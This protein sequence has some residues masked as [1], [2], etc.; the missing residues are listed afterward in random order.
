M[1]YQAQDYQPYLQSGCFY[2]ASKAKDQ[3][4]ICQPPKDWQNFYQGDWHC[5]LSPRPLA[6]QGWKIHL[7]VALGQE[8]EMLDVVSRYCFAHQ[9]SFKW[10]RS[11]RAWLL[12]NSK[13]ADRVASGKFITIYPEDGEFIQT[14][15][16]LAAL[17]KEFAPGPY[18]L[19][20]RRWQASP[21]YYRYGAFKEMIKEIAGQ[22]R[23]CLQ[24]PDGSWLEDRRCPYYCQPDFVQEPAELAKNNFQVKGADISRLTAY[25]IKGALHFSNGGG[26]YLAQK[27]GKNYVIKE[28][29]PAAGLDGHGQDA[30]S[31]IQKEAAWLKKLAN[32]P[33]VVDI[34]EDFQAWIH[35]YLVEDYVSEQTLGDYV[36]ENYPFYSEKRAA[37]VAQSLRIAEKLRRAVAHVHAQGVAIG[38]LQADNVMITEDGE[39]KLIDFEAAASLTAPY[40]PG[41]M[42]AGF[43]DWA[44]ETYEQADLYGLYQTIRFLFLPISNRARSSWPMQNLNLRCYF[45][46][47]AAD[48]LEDLR[49]QLL[50]KC[51]LLGK[52]NKDD[53]RQE[54]TWPSLNELR[55]NISRGIKADWQSPNLIKGDLPL[56]ED[57][58]QRLT[59]DNGAL[60]YGLLVAR[61]GQA[62]EKKKFLAWL[63]KQPMEELT[64]A[65][66]FT[67][68]AGLGGIVYELG[69]KAWGRQLI[70]SAQGT[71]ADLSLRSGLAG[72][73]LAKIALAKEEGLAKTVEL[74]KIGEEI[75]AGYEKM[76]GK[77]L[78]TGRLG[79]ILALWKIGCLLKREDFKETAKTGLDALLEKDLVQVDQHVFLAEDGRRMPYLA[80][81]TAGLALVLAAI[82]KDEPKEDRYQEI[83]K[84]AAE[85]MDSF[86]S[87]MGG[88]FT[89]YAGLMLPDLALGRKK[90]LGEKIRLLNNYLL[91][92]EEGTLVAASRGYRCSMDLAA[93]ASG[94]LLLLEGI[95]RNDASLWLPLVQTKNWQLF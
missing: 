65:G 71:S 35:A 23:C 51:P 28:G 24:A 20:D 66:L 44:L 86:C 84:Q 70:W 2:E 31:R 73:T 8:Q 6:Q 95:A 5:C 27:N 34:K 49:Q 21:V 9:L 3:E 72:I 12:K 60:G 93:G 50:P 63:R 52:E 87:Y 42:T 80:N 53:D 61:C 1:D 13:Y 64:A 67:G 89:G 7:S 94:V 15:F 41:I 37:Y 54:G 68:K 4:F 85:T 18:I 22:K 59:V 17:L 69:D 47:E 56:L 38:D 62:A 16:D 36:A 74:I 76:P 30:F 83:I 46:K 91:P 26:V 14:V 57:P 78:L 45:S 58:D 90:A 48:Y 77:G 79:A 82:A 40:N 55:G 29:R 19:S 33:E 81:G 25:Q 43:S 88:L 92:R 39:V 11:R 10:T 75:A 32:V